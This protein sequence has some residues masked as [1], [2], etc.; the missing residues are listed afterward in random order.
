[1]HS[2]ATSSRVMY[3]RT[4]L[5]HSRVSCV[6]YQKRCVVRAWSSRVC[7]CV[8]IRPSCVRVGVIVSSLCTYVVTACA[9]VRLCVIVC[10][11]SR[12]C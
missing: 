11:R 12:S 8:C 6:F 1:M 4:S 10:P 9:C 5:A 3:A 2:A 7:V